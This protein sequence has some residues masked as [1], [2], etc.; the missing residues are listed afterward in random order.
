MQSHEVIEEALGAGGAMSA[1]RT[2]IVR[3]EVGKQ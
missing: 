3:I 1:N 2:H